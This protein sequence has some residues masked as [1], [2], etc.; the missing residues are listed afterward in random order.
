MVAAE[1]ADKLNGHIYSH[2][3]YTMYVQLRSNPCNGFS[4]YSIEIALCLFYP[5]QNITSPCCASVAITKVKN[6]Q[7]TKQQI[8]IKKVE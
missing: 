8:S 7:L 6:A 3:L 2:L 1:A 5:V 4:Q